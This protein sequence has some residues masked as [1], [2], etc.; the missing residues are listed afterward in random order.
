VN[1]QGAATSIGILPPVGG[2]CRMWQHGADHALA[3]KRG[4]ER[5]GSLPRQMVS[6]PRGERRRKPKGNA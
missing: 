5:R 3:R 6:Q 1:G 4:I 2:T